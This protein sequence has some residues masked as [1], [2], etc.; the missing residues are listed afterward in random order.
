MKKR[1]KIKVETSLLLTTTL[2]LNINITNKNSYA[3]SEN[4]TV[5]LGNELSNFFQIQRDGKSQ[6]SALAF[7]Y[8][9]GEAVFCID[10]L[11][12]VVNGSV[13]NSGEFIEGAFYDSSGY[14]LTGEQLKQIR[15]VIFWGWDMSDDKS[16]SQYFTV[17][18]AIYKILGWSFGNITQE[19]TNERIDNLINEVNNRGENTT[20]F[21]GKT[22]EMLPNS[23]ITLTDTFG[24]LKYLE[25]NNQSGYTFNKDG[26]NLIITSGNEISD[27]DLI[28]RNKLSGLVK[29]SFILKNSGSQSL[30]AYKD[31]DRLFT[32]LKLN[33]LTIPIPDKKVSDTDEK[34]VEHAKLKKRTE[35]FLWSVKQ[36][37][38]T[39]EQLQGQKYNEFIFNDSI[40]DELVIDKDNIQVINE[41]TNQVLGKENY[42]LEVVGQD[43]K[44][45]I[46]S[47]YMLQDGFY[48][49][50]YRLDIPTTIKKGAN[51]SKY[52]E[53]DV[54]KV[55][56]EAKVIINHLPQA[57]NK[58]FITPPTPEIPIPVKK[59]SDT[60]EKGVEHARLETYGE[61]H[62]WNVD[63]K[64]NT[65]E[66]LYGK[67]IKNLYLVM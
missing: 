48:G 62:V 59:V 41:T 49:N 6:L 29:T 54:I 16:I 19:V 7:I 23:K 2:L 57:T 13:Y 39:L 27:L 51:L 12:S 10:P 9:D 67:N 66:E 24:N 36:Q 56:N 37:T 3:M 46:K 26:N 20:S 28:T 15:Q 60:D 47:D 11:V 63:Q 22:I 21:N 34:N 64:A 50:T 38:H 32:S 5:T 45:S 8:A 65:L 4:P 14:Q 18:G 30:V 40:V 33:K 58:V 25:F 1:N 61:R 42:V 35:K 43:V 52:I 44:V 17:Q 55:P 53:N 31:P